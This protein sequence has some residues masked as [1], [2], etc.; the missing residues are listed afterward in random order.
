M[1][2]KS[3]ELNKLRKKLIKHP[4]YKQIDSLENLK[5]FMETHVF[6]VWDF[7]TLV[8]RLQS[9]IAG[10]NL[11]WTPP[12]N[13]ESA[14][15]INEIVLSEESDEYQDNK[16]NS[17]F[18]IYIEAMNEIGANTSQIL[19]FIETL[20]KCNHNSELAIEQTIIDPVLKDF[21]KRT[22]NISINGKLEEVIGYFLFGREDPIPDMFMRISN[23][24][25][26]TDTNAPIFNFYLQRHIELDSTEHGPAAKKILEDIICNDVKKEEIVFQS[27]INAIKSRLKMWDF[28]SNILKQ[29]RS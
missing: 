4:L 10:V 9:D 11:P 26:L 27:G 21:V 12:K 6:A 2:K 25:C 22:I 1:Q 17:H 18:E 5:I 14:R 13:S 7:M 15:F 29:R 19:T 28:V 20:G 23:N 16:H 8:K 3:D 24:L